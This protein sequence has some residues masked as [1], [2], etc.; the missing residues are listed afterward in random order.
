MA[1]IKNVQGFMDSH[2]ALAGWSE[3]WRKDTERSAKI[4]L[5]NRQTKWT[6]GAWA[7]SFKISVSHVNA[8]QISGA[9]E[10]ENKNKQGEKKP[11]CW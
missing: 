9:M 11:A 6:S 7:Q 5:E 10:K 8:H 1:Q 2:N 3:T 4:I